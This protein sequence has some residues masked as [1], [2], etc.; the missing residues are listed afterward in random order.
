MKPLRPVKQGSTVK[1]PPLGKRTKDIIKATLGA[2]K[3]VGDA[4]K[5]VND[6]TE[7]ATKILDKSIDKS[8]E[9]EAEKKEIKRNEDQKNAA[10]KVAIRFG[11]NLVG[12]PKTRCLEISTIVFE[13]AG[14]KP[15]LH[16]N[17]DHYHLRIGETYI[18]SMIERFF[19]GVPHRL[20]TGNRN[21][22]LERLK[23]LN[24]SEEIDHWNVPKHISMEKLL[25]YYW[26]SA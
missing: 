4:T 21:D 14:V 16:R 2:V 13:K 25:E 22:L 5:A 18:D 17:K 3:G 19:K 24:E 9:A 15:Q 1:A 20:F 26:G 6:S 10:I 23:S 7:R 11:S 12:D 8:V